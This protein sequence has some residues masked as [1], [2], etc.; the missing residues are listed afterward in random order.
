MH[1]LYYHKQGSQVFYSISYVP[2]N[3]LQ[4]MVKAA[5]STL[6]NLGA[7]FCPWMPPRKHCW[8]LRSPTPP[9]PSR[10]KSESSREPEQLRKLFIR[11]LSFETTDESLRSHFEH[12]GRL[13]DLW[14]WGIQTPSA[15]EASGFS[16]TPQWWR[17]MRPWMQGHAK[18]TEELWNQT[19][20]SQE[21]ILKD[22]M[23]T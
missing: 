22:L 17:W 13:T 10:L 18:W 6:K 9:L 3:Y 12:W 7:S 4:R 8:S 20:T 21:E 14:S 23:P 19:G 15:P 16:H 2:L 11:G 1:M 5:K